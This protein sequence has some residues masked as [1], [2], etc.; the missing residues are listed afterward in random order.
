MAIV[1]KVDFKKQVTINETI[2][3]QILSY[4]F[5]N[6]IH[7]SSTDLK[8][9]TE[10]AKQAGVE[11]TK[12]CVYLTDSKIFKSNQSARNAVTKAEKKG[13]IVKNGVNKK[14]VNLNTDMNVQVE[15]IVLL[16]YKILGRETQKPQA[17]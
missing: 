15:G 10:L 14:T 11:L 1:N 7:I 13:L 17:I 9:L 2:G 3:Y 6:N 16:D 12:F 4:C 8:L 5:F